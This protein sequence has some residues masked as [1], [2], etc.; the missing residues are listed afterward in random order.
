MKAAE[1]DPAEKAREVCLTA[2]ERRMRS[3][4]ELA[5]RLRTKGIEEAVAESVLDRLESVGLI[6]DAA[7]AR[8]FVA[9][10]Q[11]TR[12]RGRRALEVE[13]RG[14]GITAP[15]IESV[16]ADLGEAEDPVEAARRALRPKVRGLAGRP[17]EEAR[18]KAQGFLLRRGFDYGTIRLALDGMFRDDEDP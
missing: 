7:Y 9:S 15:I 1:R 6:D 17:P 4:R 3:R 11:R 8:A 18:A 2:L 14:K 13:L 5:D 10:R 16:L 12:P